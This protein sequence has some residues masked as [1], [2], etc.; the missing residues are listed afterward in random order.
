MATYGEKPMAIDSAG[1]PIPPVPARRAG[2]HL[3]VRS[4]PC[5]SVERE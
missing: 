2:P 1:R 3:R 4:Q 5:S